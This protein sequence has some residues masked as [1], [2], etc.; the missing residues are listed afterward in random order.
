M[1]SL[2]KEPA[3]SLE[4]AVLIDFEG[5]GRGT[6]AEPLPIP[7]MVGILNPNQK[8][9]SKYR[10]IAFKTSWK[11]A[12]N[13][14]RFEATID[15]FNTCFE[16]LLHEIDPQLGRLVS[17]SDY[18]AQILRAYLEPETWSKVCSVLYNA[19][20][21]AKKYV[22]SHRLLESVVGVPLEVF[23]SSIF[24]RSQ[25]MPTIGGGAASACRSIDRACLQNSRWSGFSDNQ[26]K[27]LH[28]LIDYN[29]GDCIATWKILKRVHNAGY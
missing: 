2:P 28:A 26:K 20:I 29:R 19:R 25:P 3:I 17:W 10:W 27:R 9:G 15:E 6:G 24:P 18:E 11:P 5:L 22:R 12:V 7:H 1:A 23:Y 4:H 21:P 14:S 16:S 8:R 13:G